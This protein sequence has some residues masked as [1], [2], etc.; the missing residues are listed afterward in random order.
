MDD[1]QRQVRIAIFLILVIFPF[2][3]FGFMLIENFTFLES[4]WLTVVTLTTIGYGD[5]AARTPEGQIFTI[6]LVLSGLG[7]LTFF[8]QSSFALVFSPALRDLRQRRRDQRAIDEL[9]NHYIICGMGEMV[10][11]TVGYLLQS[12]EI[13]QHL[14]QEL[15][16]RPIDNF[17]GRIFGKNKVDKP[18]RF[19][20][21][22]HDFI[23]FFIRRFRQ[24][25]T[26]L[27]LIVVVT[28]DSQYAGHLR[29]AGLL[30]IEGDPA[31]DR[32]LL[33][34]GVL[35]A[36]AMM[37][38]LDSDTESLLT[39]LTANNLN[40]TL[41][42][43]AA[44]LEEDLMQKMTRA[45]ANAVIAPFDVAGQ[46]L[47]NATLRPAVN[48]FFN[49]ILF[50]LAT[51]YQITQLHL[52]DDSPWIGQ[53]ISELNLKERY[54]TGIIGVKLEDGT[55]MYAPS[56]DYILKEE[57]VLLAVAPATN[58]PAIQIECHENTQE[59]IRLP[60]W[61]RLVDT[62][63]PPSSETQYTLLE[64]EEAIEEMSNHFII[65]GT[66]RV[67]RN[68]V[69]KLDP[70]RPFVIIS[71]DNGVTKEL[72]QRGF[73]VIHGDPTN[74]ETLR[75]AGTHRAQA[76]MVSIDSR[77][78][79]VLTVLNCRALSKR[80]LITAT[81]NSDDM[82][83]KLTRAG[84]DRVVSPFHVSAQFVLLSTTRPDIS[85]FLQY[86]LYNYRTGLETA[87]LHMEEDSPW[88]GD[89]IESLKLDRLFNAGVI[90]I[91]QA[92]KESYIYAP[93][94]DYVISAHEVLIVVTPM[95]YFD[96]IR[97][98]AH[99]SATKRPKTLR[100]R[101]KIQQ[102]GTWTRDMI[103]ELIQDRT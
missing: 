83:D 31:D 94:H 38:M 15:A 52:W 87:D 28:Q 50:D 6:I 63:S 88:I 74:E 43:T 58:V 91:R 56:D 44:T 64:A 24:E 73:R 59:N 70:S 65:C 76:I 102:S 34:S 51:Q 4:T 41:Y 92:D 89:T 103:K 95:K 100:H 5:I 26:L 16:Y 21:F 20:T 25:E 53:R 69:K 62:V 14:N 32:T 67:A 47:N 10:D 23:L 42:V 86:V 9:K 93:P 78:N 39:V 66:D 57:E 30:V 85:A 37:V 3:I 17:L 98:T 79:S 71:D 48:D 8:L 101:D 18:S 29:S 75:K 84:A 72:L 35:R 46:F 40:P 49:G 97:A 61:Q 13:R 19:R 90:G 33:K 27:D 45:G 54:D 68:S 2:G 55:F 81:A 7:A 12:A 36:Q 60:L 82:I 22:V 11:K 80:L 77:A 99:G 96:E 1:I